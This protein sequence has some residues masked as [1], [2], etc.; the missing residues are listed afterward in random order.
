M[1]LSIIIISN[2]LLVQVNSSSKDYIYKS[3]KKFKN[4]KVMWSITFG[5]IIGLFIILYT[6]LSKILNLSALS[7]S[8]LL[9]VIAISAVSILWYEIVKFIKNRKH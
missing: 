4:D 7:L 2:L 3:I 9:L 1:G 5:T 8:N 6:P